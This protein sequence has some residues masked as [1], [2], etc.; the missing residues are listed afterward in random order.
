M[1]NF[2]K[3]LVLSCL[4]GIIL[5]LV[6]EQSMHGY[7]I[8]YTINLCFDVES[9]L[10]FS[11]IYSTLAKL[12]KTQCLTTNW[13]MTNGRARK[14]YTITPKGQ[15]QLETFHQNLQNITEKI[16]ET[17]PQQTTNTEV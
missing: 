2:C 8:F 12:E 17:K 6:N 13:D 11:T 15:T 1:D 10:R 14:M 16:K 9:S 4:D 3:R 5:T 7:N